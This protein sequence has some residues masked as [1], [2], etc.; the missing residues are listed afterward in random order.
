MFSV[1]VMC[2]VL[3]V[4]RSGFYAWLKKPASLRTMENGR[5][6]DLIRESQAESGGS[7]GSPRICKDLREQGEVCSENRVARLMKAHG[8]K[9]E[10][11]YRKPRYRYSRPSLATPNRLEQDFSSTA[12]DQRWVTDITYIATSEGWLYLAVVIDLYSRRVVGWSMGASMTADLVMAALLGALWRRKP[13]STVIIHSD[14]GSQFTSDAWIRFC[15][16]HNLERSMSRRGN[17]YDNA[18][19]ES[20]FSSLKKE[21]V[22]RKTYLTRDAARADIFDYIEVF[23]NRTRRHSRLGMLSPADFEKAKAEA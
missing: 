7:Y 8:I 3:R 17:C 12:P 13:T 2:R 6:I 20:F 19:V 18:V 15:R 11:R 16:D 14:Q 10:R 21:R 22:R 5:L 1:T 9:A 4:H 23:Y